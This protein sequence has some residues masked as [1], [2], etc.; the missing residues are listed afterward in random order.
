MFTWSIKNEVF[1][2]LLMH[3]LSIILNTRCMDTNKHSYRHVRTHTN[4]R[5]HEHI[6]QSKYSIWNS[7]STIF[8]LFALTWHSYYNICL[9]YIC[10]WD[11]TK[12]LLMH[13]SQLWAS[14]CSC[15]DNLCKMSIIRITCICCRDT[16]KVLANITFWMVV[17][18]VTSFMIRVVP[19]SRILQEIKTLRGS[20]SISK[21]SHVRPLKSSTKLYLL[22]NW[23]EVH[24]VPRSQKLVGCKH[25]TENILDAKLHSGNL[26]IV[27]N[28]SQYDNP[29]KPCQGMERCFLHNSWTRIVPE[30]A[31]FFFFWKTEKAL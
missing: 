13:G 21:S 5:I 19:R 3:L 12:P 18:L 15:L 20:D 25:D 2:L 27:Q 23:L 26:G 17:L 1:K 9:I 24:V 22:G 30:K 11:K 10:V 4:C 8:C 28:Q 6:C 14:H 16:Y 29:H 31:L 7:W